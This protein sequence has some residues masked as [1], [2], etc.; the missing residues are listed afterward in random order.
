MERRQGKRIEST[1]RPVSVS[2][3]TRLVSFNEDPALHKLSP[4][5]TQSPGN[6]DR[7]IKERKKKRFIENYYKVY[8]FDNKFNVSK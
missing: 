7:F 1:E 3:C 2:E 6:R 4:F 8:H 5:P